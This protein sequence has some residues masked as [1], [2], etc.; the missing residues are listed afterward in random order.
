[1]FCFLEVHRFIGI[2]GTV[3]PDRVVLSLGFI[4][5]ALMATTMSQVIKQSNEQFS[6]RIMHQFITDLDTVKPGIK[7]EIIDALDI[8]N[9]AKMERR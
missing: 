4:T 1:M 9:S 6:E 8:L 2:H 5:F 3:K 7:V